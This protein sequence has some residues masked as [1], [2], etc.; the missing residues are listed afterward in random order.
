M[1]DFRFQVYLL[2]EDGREPDPRKLAQA[3]AIE[4]M[5]LKYFDAA[6]GGR[7]KVTAARRCS[8]SNGSTNMAVASWGGLSG[9]GPAF[10][11]VQPTGKSAAGK[12]ARPT[13]ISD[14][15]ST[16][17]NVRSLRQVCNAT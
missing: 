2:H 7:M 5:V 16:I 9:R 15:F 14:A 11:R 1:H 13:T 6:T 8:A 10:Q 3:R 12:I 4:A 17:H